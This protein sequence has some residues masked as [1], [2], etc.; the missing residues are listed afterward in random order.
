ML[1]LEMGATFA[2][3][4]N[5]TEPKALGVQTPPIQEAM[6]LLGSPRKLLI[7]AVFAPRGKFWPRVRVAAQSRLLRMVPKRIRRYVGG[8][9]LEGWSYRKTQVVLALWASLLPLSV[10]VA[11]TTVHAIGHDL[12]S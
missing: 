6:A 11:L 4:E 3:R 9:L 12:F 5:L 1:I 8:K 10:Y 7:R 2:D